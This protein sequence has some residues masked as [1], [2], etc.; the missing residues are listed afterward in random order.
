M[1]PD[2]NDIDYW[3]RERRKSIARN[4]KQKH[5]AFNKWIVTNSTTINKEGVAKESI[6]EKESALTGSQ[7]AVDG[8]AD[9]P[10]VSGGPVYGFIS[11]DKIRGNLPHQQRGNRPTDILVRQDLDHF[12]NTRRGFKIVDSSNRDEY[13]STSYSQ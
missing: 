1:T 2:N 12:I 3:E 9:H 6:K 10:A 13:Y 4:Y 7:Q 8:P 11:N 5:K